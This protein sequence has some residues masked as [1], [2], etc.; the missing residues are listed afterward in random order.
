MPIIRSHAP[1]MRRSE[2]HTSELQSRENL[3][4]RLL[5]EKK[6]STQPPVRQP[7]IAMPGQQARMCWPARAPVVAPGPD[8]VWPGPDG[9]I[10]CFFVFF[11]FKNRGPPKIY[12][13]PQ[14]AP[15]PI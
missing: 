9:A 1:E 6:K 13:L 11:F 2:E 8:A 14:P 15:L 10:P 12:P 7:G 3:V 4:C 5:L